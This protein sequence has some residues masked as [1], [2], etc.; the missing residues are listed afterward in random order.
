MYKNFFIHSSVDGHLGCFHA[1]DIVNIV[2]VN[3]EVHVSFRIVVLSRYM[4]GSGM[5][6][7]CDRFIP[8][9]LRNLP[10]VLYNG[11]ISLDSHKHC[12]RVPF[13]PHP[14]QHFLFVD[15]LMMAVLT[16]VRYIPHCFDL[17]FSNKQY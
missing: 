14:L 12:K 5:A 16:G 6:G 4:P 11:Y 8:S 10:T 1:L 15:T 13:S 9:F 17:H 7:S 3:I 2:A